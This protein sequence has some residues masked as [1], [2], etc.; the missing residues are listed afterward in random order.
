MNLKK[1]YLPVLFLILC[2]HSLAFAQFNLDKNNLYKK[3]TPIEIIS[4]KMEAFSEKRMVV[5]SGHATAT[6]GD[7]ILKSDRLSFFYRKQAGKKDKVGAQEID[8]GG[9]L[10]KIEAKGNV[11]ISQKDRIA[12]GDEAVYYQE[13]GQITLTGDPVLQEGKNTIKGCKVT[14]FLN[15]NRGKVENCSSPDKKER[16][17]AIIHPQ[18]KK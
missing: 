6:Q 1:I 12:T 5:F 3:N 18:G 11:S 7:I 8:T 13:T 16:V 17:T 15:E 2:C 4:D 10:E 9:E 14:I